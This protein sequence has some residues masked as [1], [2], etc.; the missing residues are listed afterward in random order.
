MEEITYTEFEKKYKPE[1]N[2]YYNTSFDG[3]LY[4]WDGNM[5]IKAY[6]DKRLAKNRLWT[7]VEAE[8]GVYLVSGDHRV[9]RIGYMVTKVPFEGDIMVEFE[10]EE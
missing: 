2:K 7:L 1:K 5:L 9:N 10:G 4:E 6:L 8:D 3:R